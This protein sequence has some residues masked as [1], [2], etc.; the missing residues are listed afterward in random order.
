MSTVIVKKIKRR[1]TISRA[2]VREVV[3]AV[4]AKNRAFGQQGTS[5]PTDV[6]S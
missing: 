1:E 5:T 4:Y 6:A 3:A 2:K